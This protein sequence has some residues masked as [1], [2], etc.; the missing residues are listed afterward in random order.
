MKRPSSSEAC[1]AV[2]QQAHLLLLK[3]GFSVHWR[4]S[5]AHQMAGVLRHSH[6]DVCNVLEQRPI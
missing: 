1:W 3:T 5:E 4:Q 6:K 2:A